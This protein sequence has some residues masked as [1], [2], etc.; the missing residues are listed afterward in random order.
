MNIL[1]L[2]N[3]VNIGGISSYIFTLG[4]GL[5][6]RGHNV[7]V[8][9]SGGELAG[10]FLKSDIRHI[11][12]PMNTKQELNPKIL[13]SF[14]RLREEIKRYNIDLVHSNSRTT[15]VLGDL[16]GRYLRK[17]H[18]FTCHG[19]FKP[20]L[21]RRLFPCWGDCV[22]AISQEV[23]QHLVCDLGL[24]ARKI[25]VIN[26]GI[27][28]RDFGDFS[29]REKTR[30]RLG[31]RDGFLIG[32][33]ARLSDVKGHIYL[34]RAMWDI[35]KDYPSA[36]LLIAGEGRMK[37]ILAGEVSRLGIEG[38]VIFLP[39]AEN[40][41]EL[42]SAMDVFVMPSLQEGLG[43][44]LMEAMA[45]GL[46]V[47]GSA[48]GGIKTL[49]KDGINGLLVEPADHRG[50]AK[51]IAGLLRDG[52]IRQNMGIAARKFIMDDFSKEKMV[53]ATERGYEECLRKE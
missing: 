52:N 6:E 11:T 29:T 27:D 1:F 44:A 33:I 5:K 34:I 13:L 49:I 3:H 43:L 25:T 42:L 12:V 37:D 2:S 4:S 28:L 46:A 17:T 15:Q 14:F 31:V 32:I 53:A 9:S 16:L 40:S 35:T 10:R 7:Y 45:Q 8:A 47:V 41:R 50:L 39:K 26:N 22:I 38:N 18:V 19:F 23:K 20:K 36:K 30:E 21:S 48:V 51:A 24:D